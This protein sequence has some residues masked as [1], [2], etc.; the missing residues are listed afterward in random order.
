MNEIPLATLL[1]IGQHKMTERCQLCAHK[2]I[3]W[4]KFHPRFQH[5][6]PELVLES[7]CMP[8]VVH[9]VQ[10]PCQLDLHP[11]LACST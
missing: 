5:A 8:R 10:L 9:R 7:V 6:S 3:R 2:D 11:I 1:L 4:C